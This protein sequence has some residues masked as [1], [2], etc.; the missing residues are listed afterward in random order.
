MS[1]VLGPISQSDWNTMSLLLQAIKWDKSKD[2]EKFRDLE[3]KETILYNIYK[4]KAL[5]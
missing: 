3:E 5:G 2:G 4:K 1:K